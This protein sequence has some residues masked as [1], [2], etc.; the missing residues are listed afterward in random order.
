MKAFGKEGNIGD[1]RIWWCKGKDGGG[2]TTVGVQKP[3]ENQEFWWMNTPDQMACWENDTLP[4]VI[5]YNSR[6]I[7]PT[8]VNLMNWITATEAEQTLA[9]MFKFSQ[10]LAVSK[11]RCSQKR[12]ALVHGGF[13]FCHQLVPKF[14]HRIVGYLKPLHVKGQYANWIQDILYTILLAQPWLCKS[15]TQKTWCRRHH[16]TLSVQ[17]VLS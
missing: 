3:N 12:D 11:L 10:M 6:V 15:Y 16:T 9:V 5:L 14:S 1:G 13:P 4:C 8:R 7:N 17:F 2:H